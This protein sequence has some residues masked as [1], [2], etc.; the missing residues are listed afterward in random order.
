MDAFA[1]LM[2]VTVPTVSR[3]ETGQRVPETKLWP[4][5]K[6][7]TGGKITADDFL[8]QPAE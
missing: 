8:P 7:V 1:D 2:G 6:T 5:L 3:W 4:K